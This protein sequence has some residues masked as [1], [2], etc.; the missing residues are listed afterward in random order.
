LHEKIWDFQKSVPLTID[1]MLDVVKAAGFGK[2]GPHFK[3]K[4]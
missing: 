3:M 4:H 1:K 2:A